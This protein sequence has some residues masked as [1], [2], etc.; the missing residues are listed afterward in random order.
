ML[1]IWGAAV[2]AEAPFAPSAHF[3]CATGLTNV[4]GGAKDAYGIRHYLR[5]VYL[6]TDNIHTAHYN[7]VTVHIPVL[8]IVYNLSI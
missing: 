3:T 1:Q 8:N 6:F 4:C 5:I 7:A 2:A